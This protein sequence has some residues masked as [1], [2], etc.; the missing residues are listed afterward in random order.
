MS[1]VQ[2][3]FL[4]KSRMIKK[5][6][7]LFFNVDC[8]FVPMPNLPFVQFVA[9]DVETTG[10]S[11]KT[12]AIIE[13][14]GVK[15]TLEMRE[16][17]LKPKYL[18]EY[19]SFVKP[20]RLIPPEATA[21]NGITNEMVDKAPL[22][23]DVFP[24]FIRFC[25]LSSLLVAHNAS[26]DGEFLTRTLK[27]NS[28][29]ILQNPLIDSLKIT[30]KI[31]PEV[32]S[33]RLG[34]LA[35]RLADQMDLQVQNAELHRALYDC[36]VLAEIFTV[37]LRKRFGESDLTMDKALVNIEKVHGNAYKFSTWAN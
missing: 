24:A 18:G 14:A 27:K 20:D 26:F 22:P 3:F 8:Y 2:G 6:L 4:Q 1:Q 16:G 25:G 7:D 13:I 28:L 36:Q 23:Q 21:I 33:H 12:E 35:K 10:L 11:A 29:R 37:C 34:L 17:K 5:T 30:K 15:F 31:L 9:F 19:Q 32:P